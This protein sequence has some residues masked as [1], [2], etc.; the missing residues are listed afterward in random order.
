MSDKL[1]TMQARICS[2]ETVESN[3]YCASIGYPDLKSMR[4]TT[5]VL[6]LYEGEQP[7]INNW[8]VQAD[9]ALNIEDW[10]SLTECMA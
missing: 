1:K 8:D 3:L 2:E 6:N 5:A 10:P 9:K 7:S 4:N